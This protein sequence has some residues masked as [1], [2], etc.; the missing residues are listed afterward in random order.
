MLLCVQLAAGPCLVLGQLKSPLSQSNRLG[1]IVRENGHNS[2]DFHRIYVKA[3][4]KNNPI[5]RQRRRKSSYNILLSL[6]EVTLLYVV[7]GMLGLLTSSK[8]GIPL[9]T[10]V[11]IEEAYCSL[12]VDTS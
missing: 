5:G 3:L 10:T 7:Y 4:Q 8:Y 12:Q 6:N 1:R 2:E 11:G 9:I